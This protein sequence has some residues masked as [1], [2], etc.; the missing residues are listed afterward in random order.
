MEPEEGGVIAGKYQLVAPLA[1]GGMGMVWTARHVTL[2]SRLAVKFVDP[3][4]AR[5]PAFL[6]RFERE[7]RAA[8]VIESP[9]VVHVR[10]AR[11]T[12]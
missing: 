2:G 10:T 12:S 5:D 3:S 8:A 1:R 9:H 4:Y 6:V 11:R 7:A